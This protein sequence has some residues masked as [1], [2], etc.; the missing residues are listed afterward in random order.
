MQ[1]NSFNSEEFFERTQIEIN[2]L[3]TIDTP[4][5]FA[6]TEI[7]LYNTKVV[8]VDQKALATICNCPDCSNR[9]TSDCEDLVDCRCGI[10]SVRLLFVNDKVMLSVKK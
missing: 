9:V 10:L 1:I 2:E 4:D 7:T 5:D 6:D 8:P 3:A